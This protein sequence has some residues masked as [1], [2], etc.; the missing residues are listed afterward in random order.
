[1]DEQPAPPARKPPI[2]LKLWIPGSDLGALIKSPFRAPALVAPAAPPSSRP[3]GPRVLPLRRA[4]SR[5]DSSSSCPRIPTRRSSAMSSSMPSPFSRRNTAGVPGT[6]ADTSGAHAQGL[7]PEIWH[8]ILRLATQVPRLD[9][10]TRTN[11]S[12]TQGLV[13]L[14]SRRPELGVLVRRAAFAVT[15]WRQDVE[16]HLVFVRQLLDR[17]PQAAAVH[18]FYTAGGNAPSDIPQRLTPSLLDNKWK[19][20][21]LD[22]FD[23]TANDPRTME[24]LLVHCPQLEQLRLTGDAVA[25]A[26]LTMR[27]I[28][29]ATL[30]M[31]SRWSMPRLSHLTLFLTPDRTNLS[32]FLARTLLMRYGHQ[33]KFLRLEGS[34]IPQSMAGLIALCPNLEELIVPCGAQLPPLPRLRKLGFVRSPNSTYVLPAYL[35]GLSRVSAP[36]LRAIAAVESTRFSLKSSDAEQLARRIGMQVDFL[37]FAGNVI[38]FTD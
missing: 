36:S 24:R 16:R 26:R 2:A 13:D 21:S 8:R 11:C 10:R 28:R 22:W 3:T 19:W 34:Q 30:E 20:R 27:E 33:L 7:P 4:R 12:Q 29:P 14:F 9:R 31:V 35:L 25:A 18:V 15:N 38:Y 32:E 17:I 6:G 5:R 1:M 37:D 23:S